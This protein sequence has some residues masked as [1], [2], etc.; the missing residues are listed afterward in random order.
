M[1]EPFFS[2]ITPVYRIEKL[3][4]ATIESALAQTDDDW[5][6]ICIDDGSPDQA[7][8]ICDQYAAK[9]NRIH[10]IHKEN[11]GLAAARN[12]GIKMARGKYLMIL[13]GSDLFPSNDTL[14]ILKEQIIDHAFPDMVFG[15]LQ[16]KMENTGEI[17]STQKPYQIEDYQGKYGQELLA[18]MFQNEEVLGTSAPVNKLYRRNFILEHELWFYK[19]IYHD[20]DEWIPRTIALTES[21]LFLNKVIYSALTWKGCFG[22]IKSEKGIVKKA[23]D[24]CFIALRCCEDFL[25][26]FSNSQLLDLSLQYYIRY[27]ISGVINYS[28]VKNCQSKKQIMEAICKYRNVLRYSRYTS[29][30]NL[31]ILYVI[32][33][34]FGLGITV[35]VVSYRYRIESKKRMKMI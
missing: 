35:G 27:Y 15:L 12:D 10:V 32:S 25:Q 28:Q 8:A 9:H 3:I 23:C 13:E 1:K 18:L 14:R 5:E 31:K 21:T 22:N 17:T 29:S 26:R 2:I 20:D 34:V 7:G 6:M 33:K 30:R 11:E 24:K 16:D 4:S 19:G